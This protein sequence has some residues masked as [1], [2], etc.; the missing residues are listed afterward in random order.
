MKVKSYGSLVAGILGLA[1]SLT[2]CMKM[3][4][5]ILESS[6]SPKTCEMATTATQSF[7]STSSACS[8]AHPSGG[9]CS[10]TVVNFPGSSLSCYTF[11]A[12]GGTTG[13]TTGVHGTTTGVLVDGSGVPSSR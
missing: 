3:G 11:V 13:G 10:I 6:A 5:N 12:S 2:A 9:T 1:C 8:S 4:S 7:Y